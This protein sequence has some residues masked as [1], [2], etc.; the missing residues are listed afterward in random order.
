MAV[1]RPDGPGNSASQDSVDNANA[2]LDEIR[3][4]TRLRTQQS[5]SP[6]V[7][8]AGGQQLFQ[9]G[10]VDVQDGELASGDIDISG[11]SATLEQS[12]GGGSFSS[13][14]ITQPSVSKSDGRFYV[15]YDFAA[16]EWGPGDSYKLVVEGVTVTDGEGETVTLPPFTWQEQVA[17]MGSLQSKMDTLHDTRIPDILSL[18]NIQGEAEDA[19]L[20]DLSGQSPAASSV[21]D[22]LASDLEPRLPGSGTLSTLAASDVASP[23]EVDAEVEQVL[24]RAASNYGETLTDGS[25]VDVV[26]QDLDPRL[27]GTGTIAVQGDAMDLVQAALDNIQAEVE[28]AL[29]KDIDNMDAIGANSVADILHVD[30]EPRLPGS[31]T[32]STHVWNPDGVLPT[33]GTVVVQAD[34]NPLFE[35]QTPDEGQVSTSG[36]NTVTVFALGTTDGTETIKVEGAFLFVTLND[37]TSVDLTLNAEINGT[38]RPIGDTVTVSTTGG[39]VVDLNDFN[40]QAPLAAPRITCDVTG[41]DGSPTTEATVDRT[42]SHTRAT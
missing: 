39:V 12:S 7:D 32:L 15:S 40:V 17:E 18:A 9:V 8:E 31:G 3:E 42:V 35:R 5:D 23:S 37:Q 2:K 16:S 27:P 1:D 41:A 25:I 6:T 13:T 33:S 20:A 30:L 19:L 4:E 28:D 10:V 38:V 34:L 24:A 11:A 26:T 21:V 14:G 36:T 29:V 22:V